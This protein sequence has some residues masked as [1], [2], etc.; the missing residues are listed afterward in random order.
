MRA[1]FKIIVALD[2]LFSRIPTQPRA[3]RV[4]DSGI[5]YRVPVPTVSEYSPAEVDELLGSD[6]SRFLE[7]K[8]PVFGCKLLDAWMN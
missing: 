5:R 8:D 2:L 1:T 4:W 3:P 6:V 7:L